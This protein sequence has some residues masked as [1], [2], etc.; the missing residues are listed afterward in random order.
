MTAFRESL[1]RHT[2]PFI[3]ALTGCTGAVAW[4]VP[5]VFQSFDDVKPGGKRIAVCLKA[6]QNQLSSACID[7][8]A[9]VKK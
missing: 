6:H 7:D 9:W 3:A 8:L 4:D 2:L 5:L 1:E